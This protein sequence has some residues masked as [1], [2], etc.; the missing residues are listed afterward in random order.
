MEAIHLRPGANPDLIPLP[1]KYGDLQQLVGG[2]LDVFGPW[3]PE[4]PQV[5][6]WG[7]P[8]AKVLGL[9][10]NMMWHAAGDWLAGPLVFVA[11]DDRG[12]SRPLSDAERAAVLALIRSDRA[13]RRA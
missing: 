3:L 10:A 2:D 11:E 4:Y 12:A 13:A 9:R 8:A 1:R 5:F 6:A 7:N